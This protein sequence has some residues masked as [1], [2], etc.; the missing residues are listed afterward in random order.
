MKKID[1]SDVYGNTR[2]IPLTYKKREEVD[3]KFLHELSRNKHIVLH[4]GSK[5]GK[6]SL[7]KFHLKKEDYILIQCTR[8]YTLESLYEQILKNAE[9]DYQLS[10]QKTIKGGIR[11]SAQI[12][13]EAGVPFLTKAKGEGG[14][15]KSNEDP[16]TKIYKTFDID[17]NEPNDLVRVLNANSFN[18]LIVLEDFHYLE[19][20]LQRKF[21]FDLKVFHETSEITFLIVGVWLESNRLTVFNGDLSGRVININVDLWTYNDL[22]ELIES[23]F[24]LL[25]IKIPDHVTKMIIEA[26][27]ENVG[28]VQELCYKICEKQKIWETQEDYTFVGTN[29]MVIEALNSITNEM[30]SRYQ[31]FMDKFCE[32][33][34]ITEFEMY[35]WIMFAIIKTDID[36]LRKGI[37][38]NSIYS[39][40]KQY[41]PKKEQLQSTHVNQALDR[42]Y[43]VQSKHKLQPYILDFSHDD[44]YVVDAN[45]LVYLESKSEK[46][47][48]KTIGIFVEEKKEFDF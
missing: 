17:P 41:H 26:S 2:G 32:G 39:I 48:F 37:S 30:A 5:Q 28:L 7:R 33:L 29:N 13:A 38:S 42:V 40:I 11:F 27:N 36:K 12:E 4:G 3:S 25:N 20:E 23:G 44:L 47:L 21:A 19:E 46:E 16:Q 8:G 9:I 15:E 24:P 14:I 18:K 35:R 1:L 34:S 43:K 10:L 31:T 45:F 22:K 6:S